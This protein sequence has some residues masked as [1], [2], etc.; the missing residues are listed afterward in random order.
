MTTS[1]LSYL[2]LLSLWLTE[3]IWEFFGQKS[4]YY[5][6][7]PHNLTT[8]SPTLAQPHNISSYSPTLHQYIGS[9]PSFS[10]LKKQCFLS[11]S[12]F[13]QYWDNSFRDGNGGGMWGKPRYTFW[14][15]DQSLSLVHKWELCGENMGM[16]KM[17]G[18]DVQKPAV[19]PS[20]L[21]S[22]PRPWLV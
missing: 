1:V 5:P 10:L 9:F 16:G 22:V 20:F 19:L 6:L 14:A 12:T 7:L 17:L 21:P 13:C 3:N 11:S 18:K 15:A 2:V 8:I 4:T